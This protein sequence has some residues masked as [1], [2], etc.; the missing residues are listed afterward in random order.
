MLLGP[1][2]VTS[3]DG[4]FL[5]QATRTLFAMGR[6]RTIPSFFGRIHIWVFAASIP[7]PTGTELAIRLGLLAL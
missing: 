5:L 4:T 6:D 2:A 1:D 3:T 7:T